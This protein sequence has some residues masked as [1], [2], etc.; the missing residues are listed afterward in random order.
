M[1]TEKGTLYDSRI[2][3]TPSKFAKTNL[4]HLQETGTIR[5][6]EPHTNSREN[7]NSYLFFMVTKGNGTFIYNKITYHIKKGDCVFID[8]RTPY[9]HR[10]SENLWELKWVHFYGPNMKG[11]Y[12]K[13]LERGGM[14]AFSS[15]KIDEYNSIL[16]NI[17]SIAS[18]N[19]YIRDMQIFEKLTNL[20]TVLMSESYREERIYKTNNLN[21]DLQQIKEYLDQNYSLKITLQD[22]AEKFYI[23]KYYLTRIF[24]Q[25]FGVSP[26]DY[27]LHVRVTHAKTLLRFTDF[28]I[29][30]VGIECG[31]SDTNYFTRI[32]K[33]IEGYPP[34]EYR[35]R[36]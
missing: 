27:L 5:A 11:I 3:Y 18:S 22:L 2:I 1:K 13:Y 25:Q 14:P 29:E 8:C 19:E 32:F 34:G 35:K 17:F 7:L 36:W 23:N 31:I 26:I 9:S 12:D 15:K 20:L 16:N 28:S 33:K 4:L 10:S 30:K 21:I 24:K 6:K